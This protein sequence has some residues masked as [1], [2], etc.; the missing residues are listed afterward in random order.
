VW[1]QYCSSYIVRHVTRLDCEPA[2]AHSFR[3][4]HHLVRQ[5]AAADWRAL[6]PMHSSSRGS[7]LLAYGPLGL[8]LTLA[9]LLPFVV[10]TSCLQLDSNPIG[11]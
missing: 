4:V 10:P 9:L 3:A 8:T 1:C 6:N 7:F 5:P 11:D 2:D